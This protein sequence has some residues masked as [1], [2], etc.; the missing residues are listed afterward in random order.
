LAA[1]VAASVTPCTLKVKGVSHTSTARLFNIVTGLVCYLGDSEALPTK[2]EHLWLKRQSLE[3][4]VGVK[5]S[6]NF[7]FGS[8]DNP[9]TCL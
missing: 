2:L 7:L 1:T 3:R 8:Y 9:R 6:N 5:R 4:R